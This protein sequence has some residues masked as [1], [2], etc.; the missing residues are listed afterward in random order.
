M[1][2]R[3]KSQPKSEFE[4]PE[5]DQDEHPDDKKLPISP[6]TGE[7]YD[8]EWIARRPCKANPSIISEVWK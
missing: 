5:I 3:K 4:Q 7:T 6:F 8:P 2:L 1:S